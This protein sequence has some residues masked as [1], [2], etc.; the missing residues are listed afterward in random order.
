MAVVREQLPPGRYGRS[1]DARADHRL[2]ILAVVFGVVTVVLVGWFGY[3][4]VAGTSVSGEIIKFKRVSANAVEVHLE[5]RKDEGA[6]G[7]CTLRALNDG[8]EEVGRKDVRFTASQTRVDQ[9]I[10]VRTTERA[11]AAELVGCSDSDG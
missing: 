5:V 8:H 6:T 10:T 4:Y 1:A 2:R 7:T 3:H 11:T 9:I